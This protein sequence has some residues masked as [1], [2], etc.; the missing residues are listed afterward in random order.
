MKPLTG[1]VFY[2]GFYFCCKE[3]EMCVLFCK[4]QP[5]QVRLPRV[6]FEPGD[7]K[8]QFP[9]SL[10]GSGA[11]RENESIICDGLEVF[12]LSDCFT[13]L[14]C[15]WKRESQLFLVDEEKHSLKSLG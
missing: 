12:F 6:L 1:F 4:Q 15:S 3:G 13:Y 8:G 7:I 11:C 9:C 2:V 14:K 10:T 5:A